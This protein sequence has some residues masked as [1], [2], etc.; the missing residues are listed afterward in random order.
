MTVRRIVACVV[1]VAL[2]LVPTLGLAA[3]GLS[4]APLD[5]HHRTL[6]E[7][8]PQRGWR[9]VATT[10]PRWTFTPLLVAI[11]LVD[12]APGA[13]AVPLLVRIPFVPPRA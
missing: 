10:L 4:A 7:H 9:T 2:A 12:A 6:L 5:K 11:A 13:A 8:H 1:L 3:D